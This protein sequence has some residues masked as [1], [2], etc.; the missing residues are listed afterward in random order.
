[1]DL[2]QILYNFKSFSNNV[3]V[4]LEK[5]SED[6]EVRSRI[7][8]DFNLLDQCNVYLLKKLQRGHL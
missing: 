4:R 1:M 8:Y 6:T 5:I 2:I 7:A 3:K